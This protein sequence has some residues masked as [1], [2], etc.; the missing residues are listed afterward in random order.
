MKSAGI[1]T[2][3]SELPPPRKAPSAFFI[4]FV[5]HGLFF[6]WLLVGL[7][8]LPK[9]SDQILHDRYT[10]RVLEPP[11]L[12]YP[13]PPAQVADQAEPAAAQ[14]ATHDVASSQ[15]GGSPAPLSLPVQEAHLPERSQALIQPDAPPELL[16][17]KET[18]VPL[19]V[20]WSPENSPS[21]TIVPPPQQEPTVAKMR[22]AIIKPN[23]EAKLQDLNIATTKMP[24][25][26][27][28]MTA[29]TT[30]P[31]V[32]RGPE[33]VS[34][35]PST[36]SA[37]KAENPTP[38]RIVSLS[39]LQADGPVV[40]PLANQLA[41]GNNTNKLA[42]QRAEAATG[43]GGGNPAS[44]QT[45]IGSG[46]GAGNAKAGGA[47]GTGGGA[48]GSVTVGMAGGQAVGTGT[49]IPSL[50][51]LAMPRDGQ[52]GVVVVGTS[53]TDQYPEVAE[54]WGGRLVYTVYLHVGAKKNWVLQYSL[55]RSA[56]DA[57][58]TGNV[59]RPEAPWPFDVLRPHLA[60]EDYNSDALIIHGFINLAG[61]FEKLGM[62]FPSGFAQAKF[63]LN[64]LQQ[65]QFRPA[66]QN[67]QIAAVEVLLIIPEEPAE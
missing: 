28:M 48:A 17:P 38:A 45:G 63:V 61:R 15:G 47:T 3:F 34:Q 18:P 20:L 52:F 2:L 51:H 8:H 13:R 26:T 60:P 19:A 46:D 14:S 30:S 37:S 6:T 24:A 54:I 58:V 29:G 31:V 16:L 9:V 4:S 39:P 49:G 59:A 56:A 11:R 55:P 27:P 35:V 64:A 1:V 50:V 21:K 36:S 43:N 25:Q 33:P 44:T 65:W 42:P 67:G 66:K 7:R 53:V 12:Q 40:I 23:R 41:Q 10:V 57:V 5:V 32:V 22:P 62:V